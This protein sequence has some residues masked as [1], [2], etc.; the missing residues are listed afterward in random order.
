[1][2]LV[3]ALAVAAA[4][5]VAMACC[6]EGRSPSVRRGPRRRTTA[7]TWLATPDGDIAPAAFDASSTVN[8][9]DGVTAALANMV[10]VP[11]HAGEHGMLPSG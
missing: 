2:W 10:A 1:M 6:A 3:I 7:A 8:A 4:A 9:V 11:V 5:V